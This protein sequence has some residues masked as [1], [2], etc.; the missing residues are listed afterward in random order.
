MVYQASSQLGKALL[1]Q[2]CKADRTK[3]REYY[4][5]IAGISFKRS[6]RWSVTTFAIV[7]R[8]CRLDFM[9]FK[10]QFI[11]G[12]PFKGGSRWLISVFTS[13]KWAR[14]VC[15]FRRKLSFVG[16]WI[17]EFG[18]IGNILFARWSI[19]S[20]RFCLIGHIVRLVLTLTLKPSLWRLIPTCLNERFLLLY[21]MRSKCFI[22]ARLQKLGVITSLSWLFS[23]LLSML[24]LNLIWSIKLIVS[25]FALEPDSWIRTLVLSWVSGHAYRRG[26]SRRRICCRTC[27]ILQG[28]MGCRRSFW[29]VY[30][31]NKIINWL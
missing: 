31:W 4:L 21:F 6:T 12:F 15:F 20:L 26:R 25:G 28:I 14:R 16:R 22:V 30:A 3:S 9:R 13:F 27:V 11:A 19:K 1:A 24:R 18:R 7:L 8:L 17:L 2:F 10:G 23:F 29:G 5:S